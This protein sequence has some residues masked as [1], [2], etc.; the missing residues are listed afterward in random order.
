LTF[1]E[2]TFQVDIRIGI[3]HTGKE[4]EVELGEGGDR[5]KLLGDIESALRGE[6]GLLWLTDK[7]GRQFCVP[8]SKIAYVEVGA[9]TEE[10]RVGFGAN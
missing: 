8:A 7:R 5:E 10:R 9:S 6:E 2:E 1:R 3:I 4:L